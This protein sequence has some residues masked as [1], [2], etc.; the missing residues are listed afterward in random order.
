MTGWHMRPCSVC[1]LEDFEAIDG[2]ALGVPGLPHRKQWEVAQA[3]GAFRYL[4]HAR[5]LGIG[6]GSEATIYLLTLHGEVHATDLYAAPGI[7]DKHASAD[8]LITP[9]VFAPAVPWVPRNLIVQHMDAR[10]LRYPDAY[11]DGVFSSS[12]IEHMGTLDDI[13]Q[14]A[15]EIGRV[16]KPGGLASLSTEWKLRGQGGGFSNIVLFDEALLRAAVIAP[17]GCALVEPLDSYVSPATRA[18][19]QSLDAA[20]KLIERGQ[21]APRP[22]IVLE[23]GE[24]L[25]TS[26][27]ILLRKLETA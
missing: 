12:S 18:T 25:F 14:V 5:F 10:T 23:H 27:H 9:E 21:D 24:Y 15:R 8:M 11:F 20:V 16:L 13:A 19:A 22:H 4:R 6:A 1:N 17:S 2:A 26:V 3:Y 7:W